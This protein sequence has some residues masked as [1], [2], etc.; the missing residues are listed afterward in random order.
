MATGSRALEKLKA[1]KSAALGRLRR[2]GEKSDEMETKGAGVVAG[3]VAAKYYGKWLAKR[4]KDGK[5][6]QIAKV[7]LSYGRAGA[8]ALIGYGMF[9]DDERTGLGALIAGASLLGAD[10]GVSSYVA[11]MAAEKAA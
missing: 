3:F 2:I 4:V 8:A 11:E 6:T 5:S 1:S 7:N 10:E 9:S